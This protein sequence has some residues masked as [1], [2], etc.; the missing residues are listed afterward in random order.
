VASVVSHQHW[1]TIWK[2]T[3]FTYSRK[4]NYHIILFS[5][6]RQSIDMNWLALSSFWDW[7]TKSIPVWSSHLY[8]TLVL[9]AYNSNLF[10]QQHAEWHNFTC[11]SLSIHTHPHNIVSIYMHNKSSF[12]K[13]H[14]YLTSRRDVWEN[15]VVGHSPGDAGHQLGEHLVERLGDWGSKLIHH[16]APVFVQELI[17]ASAWID[18]F[19]IVNFC[20]SD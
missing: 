5:V 19:I 16:L 18:K 17:H 14:I 6:I 3:W 15:I 12:L 7:S 11:L 2:S 10:I 13:I 1:A 9:F 20:T 8:G 4:K